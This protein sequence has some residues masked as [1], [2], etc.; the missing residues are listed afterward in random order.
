MKQILLLSCVLFSFFGFSQKNDYIKPPT[1]TFRNTLPVNVRSEWQFLDVEADTIPGTSLN[2]AYKEIIKNKKGKEIIVAVLDTEYDITHKDLKK[3]I[4]IN[5]NEIPDNKIDDDKN[6]YI[7]DINGWNFVG[8]SQGESIINSSYECT[9]I[10]RFFKNNQTK[11]ASDS[12]LLEKANKFQN[13]IDESFLA[14]KGRIDYYKSVFPRCFETIKKFFP[15]NDYTKSEIDSLFKLHPR[16]I[17]KDLHNDLFLLNELKKR[18]LDSAWVSNAI[19]SFDYDVKTIYNKEYNEKEITKDDNEN[20]KDS[21]YGSNNVSKFAKKTWHGTQV[22]GLISS[23]YLKHKNSKVRVMP[24]VLSGIEGEDNDKDILIAIKYAVNNGAKVINMSSG[25]HLSLHPKWLRDAIIY[26]QKND[27]LLITSAGNNGKNIDN[28]HRYLL[29]YDEKTGIEFCDNL[30]KV[31]GISYYLDKNLPL[32]NSNYGRNNVDVFAPSAELF[33]PDAL[34]G[35]TFNSGTSL[36]AALTT[37]IAGLIR[38]YYPILTA[39]EVKQILLDSSVK[40]DLEVQVPGE[41][42]GTLKP[43]SEL[44]K[45]GGVVNAYNALLLAKKYS[46]KK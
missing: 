37:G 18:D 38:S 15:E 29:D 36:G 34:E 31:G 42:E 9:R 16:S 41:K 17:D 22:L 43:F 4:W 39:A 3:S 21:I 46:K 44:S 33:V 20:I 19:N 30:I 14:D 10:I 45:S 23:C 32:S 8:N 6:G 27:V 25:K 11:N 12:L 1:F 26:A 5:Q 24:I 13:K 7:D 2:K 40:Y 28:E 35:N